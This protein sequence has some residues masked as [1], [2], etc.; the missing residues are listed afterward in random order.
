MTEPSTV[1]HVDSAERLPRL[2]RRKP[3]FRWTDERGP[4]LFMLTGPTSVGSAPDVGMQV[5]SLTVSRLHAQLELR[6]TGLWI[7]DLGSRNGTFIEAVRVTE[8]RVEV[9]GRVRLGSVVLTV[10]LEP[11]PSPV[12]LWPSEQFG[13]LWGRSFVM[14]AL[15]AQLSRFAQVDSTVLLHGETGTG[16]DVVARAI[17]A[18]SA[19]AKQPFLTLD[20]A[21]LTETLA[22]SEM[23]GS[24]R[25]AFTG[26][27]K[28]R[29][30]LF[31]EADGG[32][33]FLDEI[34]ELPLAL[35][36]KLLRVLETRSVRRLGESSARSVDVR[37]MAATH[38]NL[39]EMV[40]AGTFRE[41]LYFRLA[42]LRAQV[43][44]LRDRPEDIPLLVAHFAKGA[45]IEHVTPE[46]LRDFQQRPWPGNV[47]QLRNTLERLSALGPAG[48]AEPS[49]PASAPT[50]APA[51]ATEEPVPG[52]LRAQREA[53][54]ER[55]EVDY[56][57]RLL[58]RHPNDVPAAA[59]EAGVDRSYL[60][61]L[62]R[63]YGIGGS[64][65][66]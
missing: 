60:Y 8:G 1:D 19:R 25:G 52:S 29:P 59:E 42:V 5:V 50:L 24:V 34:G 3:V 20:C 15:F 28:D 36:P 27:L 14:R 61:R 65:A 31:E 12:E 57:K 54:I 23:F 4:Q 22:E 21:S 41:D 55:F 58:R 17:H 43:P 35:Q 64:G 26:A 48:A 30:G 56:V 37:V 16:K 66:S 44:T 32:T 11:T 6:E 63:R 7:R 40:T 10:E 2:S 38:R 9:P 53:V 49:P 18:E 62:M 45:P 13:G 33:L 46:L 47:R 51:A 39:E